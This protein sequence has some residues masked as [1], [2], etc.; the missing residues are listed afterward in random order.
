MEFIKHDKKP[1]CF[2]L[3]Y[4]CQSTYE[5]TLMDYDPVFTLWEKFGC[6][7]EY[8]C[9]EQNKQRSGVHFH[10]IVW[11]PKNLY[12]KRLLPKQFHLKLE[13]PKSRHAWLK[14]IM[15]EQDELTD[16]EQIDIQQLPR[17]V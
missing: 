11:I 15:K 9:E 13:E 10:G 7:I 5:S 14:Y 17:L 12:R 3:K 16:D 2:T 4:L 1:F 8:N 6:E